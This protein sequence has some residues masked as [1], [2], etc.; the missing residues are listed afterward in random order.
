M[1]GGGGSRKE[2]PQWLRMV[3]SSRQPA[4]GAPDLRSGGSG[5]GSELGDDGCWIRPSLFTWER[6]MNPSVGPKNG[7]EKGGGWKRG[8]NR[9]SVASAAVADGAT[10]TEIRVSGGGRRRV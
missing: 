4:A 8:G 5:R 9:L 6:Q 3:E 2:N 1:E 7:G 10:L